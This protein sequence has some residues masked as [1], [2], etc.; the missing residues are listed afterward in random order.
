VDTAKGRELVAVDP[1]SFDHARQLHKGQIFTLTLYA[2]A[3]EEH[4]PHKP[5]ISSKNVFT[6]I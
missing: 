1:L 2:V 5:L 6:S 4:A 3:V